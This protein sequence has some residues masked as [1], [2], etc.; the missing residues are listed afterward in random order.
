MAFSSFKGF[1]I[2]S[3]FNFLPSK[4]ED[5]LNL[6]QLTIKEREHLVEQIGIRYR[7]KIKDTSTIT[8]AFKEAIIGVLHSTKWDKADIDLLVVVSQSNHSMLPSLSCKLHGILG[9]KQS[10]LAYDLS[11][12]CSGYVN[13]LFSVYTSLQSFGK[14]SAKAILCCGDFSSQLISDDN[15]TCLPIFSDA[16]SASAIELNADFQSTLATFNQETIG[17]GSNAICTTFNKKELSMKMNGLDVFSY[18]SEYVPENIKNLLEKTGVKNTQIGLFILHQANK[19]INTSIEKSVGISASQTASSLYSF[20]NTSSASI[21]VTLS[22]SNSNIENS[23][24][25]LCGFGVGFS[26]ASVLLENHPK[27]TVTNKIGDY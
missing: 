8:E 17:E 25:L 13:G 9:L 14:R 26:I 7:Y 3:I 2:K 16:V 21:P 27:I 10:T 24:Y 20:G 4:R 23:N 19:I 18:S 5:N 6:E 12:G 15:L 1:E 22:K 11:L